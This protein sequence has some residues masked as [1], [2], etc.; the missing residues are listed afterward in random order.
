MKAIHLSILFMA[1]LFIE[2]SAAGQSINWAN[3]PKEKR[4]I[5]N[6]NLGLDNGVVFGAAYGYSLKTKIPF[7]LC[8]EYSFPSGKTLL[9]DYKTKVGGQVR[10]FQK[11][12]IQMSTKVYGIFRRYENS[13]VRLMNFGSDVSGVVGY[14]KPRWFI[15]G[16]FGFDKAIVTN[17]KHSE[18]YKDIFPGVKDGWYEPA[19]GGNFNYGLQGGFSFKRND[20][21]LKAGRL[22][23]QDFKTKPFVPFYFQLGYNYKFR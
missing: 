6:I 10:I 12:K 11:G 2:N 18:T 23:T 13:L 9:D 14:Y 22:I 5:V 7:I 4:H 19:T 8:A 15:A 1:M 16:E 3:F 20:I 21:F 17:F